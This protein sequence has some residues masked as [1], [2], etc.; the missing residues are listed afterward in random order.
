VRGMT[1]TSD[2]EG[3][4]DFK[5]G[6]AAAG[7]SV[8]FFLSG[9]PRGPFSWHIH[10]AGDMR[11]SGDGTLTGGVVQ[12]VSKDSSFI[13]AGLPVA[14]SFSNDQLTLKGMGSIIGRSVVVHAADGRAVAQCVVGIVKDA[15]S[16]RQAP[17]PTSARVAVAKFAQGATGVSGTITF[18]QASPTA[19]TTITVRLSGLEAA[20]NKFHIHNFPVDGACSSTGGHFDPM[21]VE[22]P[23]YTT[24][25]GD[26]AA[27][28]TGCYVG[29]LS[30]KFGTLGA[31][32]S[33]SF[34]DSSVSLFG[35]NSIQGRSI[36]IHKNDGS[37]WTCATIGYARP[38]K[39]VVATFSSDIVG[40]VVMKQLADDAL[41]ETQVLVDL[42]YADAATAATAG[43]KMH[44]HVSPVTTD[45][46]SAGGHFDPLGVESNGYTTCTGN[47][48]A[49]AVGCY[50]GDLS[51]KHGLVSIGGSSAKQFFSDLNLPL[52]GAQSIDGRSIVLHAA[53][54][55]A[56]RVGCASA[57]APKSCIVSLWGAWSPCSAACGLGSQ[58]RTRQIIATAG[59]SCAGRQLRQQQACRAA[60][61][62][63]EAKTAMQC[64]AATSGK[65]P[66]AS[67]VI[68]LRLAG[69]MSGGGALT[70]IAEAALIRVVA[71]RL[72]TSEDNISVLGP[73]PAPGARRL[74]MLADGDAGQ[75]V[76]LEI[77]ADKE[78][79][80]AVAGALQTF[81]A[82]EGGEGLAALLRT[83]D[84]DEFAA[85]SSTQEVGGASVALLS[86]PAPIASLD[87]NESSLSGVEL[88]FIGIGVGLAMGVGLVL[89]VQ[90]RLSGGE[91]SSGCSFSRIS[92]PFSNP[93]KKS[94]YGSGHAPGVELS[95]SVNN[96][97][98][99]ESR[100]ITPP[101]SNSWAPGKGPPPRPTPPQPPVPPTWNEGGDGTGNAGQR[102]NI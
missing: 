100:P 64:P 51:G 77:R 53:N 13:S 30:G 48:A 46:A 71:R 82:D 15:L 5:E 62:S 80:T 9:L 36:V 61:P 93:L 98:L 14:G 28:A 81:A 58:T 47:A 56:P 8:D 95:S 68:S 74:R 2:V 42:K 83:E 17:P 67:I 65:S 88:V 59:S 10:R 37:R 6:G 84:A 12:S 24:C 60:P 45:C 66:T 4:L 72:G 54:S 92:N 86:K 1:A 49:K 87:N 41:S 55:G 91:L 19:A 29:D 23:T 75:E 22:V 27:K 97:G 3:V 40:Q 16:S 76:R 89:Y 52:S 38:V 34:M 20:T 94:G 18:S 57:E 26:A 39:T 44:V 96:P 90:R 43:H 70:A 32:S 79:A 101:S 50:L 73:A 7:V 99:S 33:A 35:A 21:G 31:S 102:G 78:Q 25:T 85:L 63:A 69:M 11:S